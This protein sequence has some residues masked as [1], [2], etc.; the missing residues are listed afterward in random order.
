MHIVSVEGNIGSGKSS[1]I[2]SLNELGYTTEQEPMED[3][4]DFL[5]KFYNEPNKFSFALQMKILLSQI[6]MVE[7]HHNTSILFTERSPTTSFEI[8]AQN[9]LNEHKISQE[10]FNLYGSYYKKFSWKPDFVIYLQT[11][12][13]QCM[14]RIHKR[15]RECER[16]ISVSYIEDL[17]KLHNKVYGSYLGKP[18]IFIIDASQSE[19]T[20]LLECKTIIN[21]IKNLNT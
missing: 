2:N 7:N 10:E 15:N 6:Q 16:N 14:D 19:Q 21:H 20:V 9:L 11:T 17:N 5:T 3:W 4:T 12:S 1:L 13:K 18:I 8:F